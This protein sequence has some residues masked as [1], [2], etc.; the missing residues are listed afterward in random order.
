MKKTIFRII[1][2][3]GTTALV[4]LLLALNC[5]KPKTETSR[6][7]VTRIIRRKY[8]SY[9]IIDLLMEYAD[10][11]STICTADE[12]HRATSAVAVIR[13]DT[14]QRTLHLRRSV[15]RWKLT[16]DAPDSGPDVPEDAYF[17][18][19]DWGAVGKRIDMDAYI[20]RSWVIPDEDGSLYHKSGGENWYYACHYI[21][22][23]YK[24]AGGRVYV[25]NRN[26]F[27]WELTD[28]LY[29]ELDF[30]GNYT[31]ITKEKAEALIRT[32]PKAD[33]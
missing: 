13:S 11:S 29:S 19:D 14:E 26:T 22:N 6:K 9:E 21:R 24:T 8:P 15:F 25:L 4:L 20:R 32:C 10:W 7:K 16:H 2:S 17:M 12:E 31:K 27:A 5:L 3:I 28:K 33:P 18:E 30:Y 23:L 1:G